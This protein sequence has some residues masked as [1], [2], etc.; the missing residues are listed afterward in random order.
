MQTQPHTTHTHTRTY[1]RAM[2]LKTQFL[3]RERFFKED[4]KENTVYTV[5]AV[6]RE[7][8]QGHSQIMVYGDG[9][10]SKGAF[11]E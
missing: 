4:S 7:T 5:A 3:K 1:L 11:N 6:A 8:I 2:G 10:Q 9:S